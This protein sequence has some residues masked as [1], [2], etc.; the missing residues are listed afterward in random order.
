MFGVTSQSVSASVFLSEDFQW[1]HPSFT[2]AH[3]GVHEFSDSQFGHL[4]AVGRN[5]EHVI[6]KFILSSQ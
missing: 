1:H 6:D 2:G 5:R 4:F 3:G